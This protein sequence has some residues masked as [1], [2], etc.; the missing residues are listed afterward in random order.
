LKKT[1]LNSNKEPA[2]ESL[3]HSILERGAVDVKVK[4]GMNLVGSKG[5]RSE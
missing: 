4:T 2:S 1:N 3:G 5:Q